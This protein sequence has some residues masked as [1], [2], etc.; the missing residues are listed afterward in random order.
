MSRFHNLLHDISTVARARGWRV[1]AASSTTG[2][3]DTRSRP[4]VGFLGPRTA[5]GPAFPYDVVR[6]SS[7][8]REGSVMRYS[9][10]PGWL[11][12]GGLAALAGP[13]AKTASVEGVT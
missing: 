13:P 12:V 2:R 5:R 11:L 7:I 6:S 4:A 10:A 9:L 3:A 8:H 1:A